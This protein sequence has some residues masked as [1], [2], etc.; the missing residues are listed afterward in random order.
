MQHFTKR[1]RI[2]YR[3]F[4]RSAMGQRSKGSSQ[5]NQSHSR[6]QGQ[7]TQYLSGNSRVQQNQSRGFVP[8][9]VCVSSMGFKNNTIDINLNLLRLSDSKKQESKAILPQD[10]SNDEERSTN[11]CSAKIMTL[12]QPSTVNQLLTLQDS[13]QCTPMNFSSRRSPPLE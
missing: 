3:G 2:V 12:E 11:Q 8:N 13:N 6:N 10:F 4:Q 7:S 9:K 5:I 1:P